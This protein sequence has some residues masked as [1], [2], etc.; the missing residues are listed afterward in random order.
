MN[1]SDYILEVVSSALRRSK[2]SVVTKEDNDSYSEAA[3]KQS[4][5]ENDLDEEQG[6]KW[7][8]HR[9][10]YL[11]GCLAASAEISADS[12]R[13]NPNLRERNVDIYLGNHDRATAV[14]SREYDDEDGE[15][16]NNHILI[17]HSRNNSHLEGVQRMST[18]YFSFVNVNEEE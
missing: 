17:D 3:W 6:N 1:S 10:T 11:A 9:N 12:F 15:T 16:I 14:I 4:L 7:D 13:N 8:D 18:A 5:H 2:E